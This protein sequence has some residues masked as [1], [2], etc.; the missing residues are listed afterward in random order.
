MLF[1][2]PN[3]IN[4]LVVILVIAFAWL[5]GAVEER[6]FASCLALEWTWGGLHP[7][8]FGEALGAE[9]A[10]QLIE[11]ALL[12]GLA[13]SRQRCWLL[14]ASSVALTEAATIVAEMVL[15][16]HGWAFGTAMLI[17][18]HLNHG[19]LAAATWQSWRRRRRAASLA[20]AGLAPQL[21]A[22]SSR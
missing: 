18:E 7:H 4:W 5:K 8:H 1:V 21:R 19:L 20:R 9:L 22:A 15:H 16:V 13:L 17:W 2:L 10:I 14:A 11:V 6:A 12:C 3:W